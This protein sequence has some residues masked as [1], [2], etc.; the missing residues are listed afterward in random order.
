ML[1]LNV[2]NRPA[3]HA[4]ITT[5]LLRYGVSLAA[6]GALLEG[7]GGSQLPLSASPQG[8]APQ[9]SLG[10]QEFRII[11]P[12]GRSAKDGANPSADLIDLKGTLYGTTVNGGAHNGG[13]VFSITTNGEE[14]VLYSFG[15]LG[16]A[17]PQSEHGPA[18]REAVQQ[19]R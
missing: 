2:A 15:A 4:V 7:C 14:R 10:R 3:I 11:H 6:A 19:L 17:P 5:A 13:T 1:Q 9:P 12:F 8:L 16:S 18:N